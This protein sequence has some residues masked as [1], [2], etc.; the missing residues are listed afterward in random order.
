[1]FVFLALAIVM[2]SDTASSA[3]AHE[4]TNA[5]HQQ[6]PCSASSGQKANR[7]VDSVLSF[8]YRDVN[9]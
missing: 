5:T 8:V 2:F 3:Y 4:H 7:I 1:M 6:V 9:Y